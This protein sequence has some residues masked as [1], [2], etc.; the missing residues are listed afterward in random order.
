MRAADIG[1]LLVD[2]DLLPAG[3]DPGGPLE[4]QK[5]YR[6][7]GFALE[8]GDPCLRLYSQFRTTVCS[9]HVRW[10][11]RGRL[12]TWRHRHDIS[13]VP[14]L[15]GVPACW[16]SGMPRSLWAVRWELSWGDLS[17]SI[18]AGA[19][20][21]GIVA[22]PGA[23][24]ALL[25]FYV[26]D[27]QTIE[28][29]KPVAGTADS[30]GTK[31]SRADIV[32]HFGRNRTLLFNNLAFAANTF[33]TTSLLTW[34][35]TYFHRLEGLPIS[36]AA[37]KGGLVMLM[38]IVG[39]PA[40]GLPGGQMARKKAKRQAAVSSP[41]FPSDIDHFIGRV[42]SDPRSGPVCNPVGCRL[43]GG[44]VRTC[45]CRS[46]PGRGPSRAAGRVP[47]LVRHHSTHSWKFTGAAGHRYTVG[48]LRIGD[49]PDFPAPFHRPGR[50][51]IPGRR[52]FPFR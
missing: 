41:E 49:L 33:V 5:E 1:G 34:L 4:S 44:H 20:P 52:I 13:H 8:P 45:G 42:Y 7:D 46:H 32:R 24:V 51:F 21:L 47:E 12:C 16:D 9:P 31:M 40:G 19:M 15:S 11:R 29:L 38:A 3:V 27:Y 2:P 25:F 39:S 37:T 22:L 17:Q 50:T 10:Y 48:S 28:L 6:P 26:R 23:I 18:S 30:A 14:G 43:H 36:K 35:P